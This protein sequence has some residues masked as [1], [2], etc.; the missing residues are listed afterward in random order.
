MGQTFIQVMRR[1]KLSFD[2]CSKSKNYRTLM[3]NILDDN[4]EKE[5]I[6]SSNLTPL[7]YNY[8]IIPESN[9]SLCFDEIFDKKCGRKEIEKKRAKKLRDMFLL[10]VKDFCLNCKIETDIS[11]QTAIP[12]LSDKREYTK[13]SC[14]KER[15]K[16]YGLV[17][18]RVR[19]RKLGKTKS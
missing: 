2:S 6:L 14:E 8:L 3:I 1:T 4:L 16:Y 10:M 7:T 17:I 5:S 12:Y 18:Q 9:N 11:Y 15:K 13:I 19:E